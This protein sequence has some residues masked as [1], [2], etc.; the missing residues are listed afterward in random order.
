MSYCLKCGNATEQKIPAGDN[1][2]RSVCPACDYIHYENPKN[3]VGALVTNDAGEVLLCKRAIEPRYGLWTL[4]A[5]FMENGETLEQGAARETIEEACAEI[6]VGPLL[7]AVSIP[8]IAQVYVIFLA[9]LP[10]G[11][12]APGPES[13]ETAWVKPEDI[14]WDQLAFPVITQALEYWLDGGQPGATWSIDFKSRG[15]NPP[16]PPRKQD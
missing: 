15:Q 12:H 6:E 13:L 16:W 11:K 3:I 1:R 5:G 14:P 8:F 4:P 7:C 10:N 9:T 2:P